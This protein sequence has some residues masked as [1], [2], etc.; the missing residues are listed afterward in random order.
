MGAAPKPE[1]EAARLSALRSYDI[2]DTL[3]EVEFDDIV[4]LASDICGVPIALVSLV[5]GERQ[6][7]KAKTGLAAQETHRDLAF[8]AHAILDPN[9]MLIVEDATKDERFAANPLVTGAPDIRFYA[10]QP[11]LTPDGDALGTLCVIDT[12]P[13]KLDANQ[14]AAL[15][16]LSSHVVLLLEKRKAEA[17]LLLERERL[18]LSL[19]HI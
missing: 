9:K 4:Q 17:E 5:D 14:I 19:I 1:G 12:E 2:L 6:W 11:L 13:R 15:E 8:C 3:P 7:F 10:G 18:K 16:T